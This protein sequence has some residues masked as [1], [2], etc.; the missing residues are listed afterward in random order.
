MNF[1]NDS[2]SCSNKSDIW[3]G[4]SAIRSSIYRV[5]VNYNN[6]ISYIRFV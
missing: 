6:N 2:I 3:T 5:V 4:L 1:V